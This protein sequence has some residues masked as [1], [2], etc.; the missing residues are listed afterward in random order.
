MSL[1][2]FRIFL[3]RNRVPISI[4][5]LVSLLCAIFFLSEKGPVPDEKKELE[6]I[7]T[8]LKNQVGILESPVDCSQDITG[9]YQDDPQLIKI[10][11]E[12]YLVEPSKKDYNLLD[13]DPAH[14]EGQFNQT[15]VVRN[16]YDRKFVNRGF[17]IESGGFD[18]E[19]ISNTLYFEMKEG[20]KGLLVEPDPSNYGVLIG[21]NRKA[22]TAQNCLA[23]EPNPQNIGF[24]FGGAGGGINPEST[25]KVTCLP[26]TSILLALNNPSVH[27]F[28]L[29]V[30]G[31]ENK[32]LK[33]IDWSLVDIWMLDMEI[34]HDPVGRIEMR[35][36]LEANN[37][38][39]IGTAFEH[40]MTISPWPEPSRA[41]DDF[42]MR[43][44][45][46]GEIKNFEETI[47]PFFL[48]PDFVID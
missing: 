10:I 2:L 6:G 27:Y 5:I 23:T 33:T 17:Y 24:S 30:E 3:Q 38:Q 43:K 37:Y 9:F 29:D 28:S 41:V 40:H 39:Y 46:M 47:K 26:I 8:K 36:L 15:V 34:A 31:A 48:D 18:G 7:L 35:K 20:W 21:K 32:I 44:D 4:G 14:L 22:W 19:M 45:K 25:T 16:M 13:N 11:K 1:D 42:Y 12:C